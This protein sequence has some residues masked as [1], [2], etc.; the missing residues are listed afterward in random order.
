[1]LRVIVA[2]GREDYEHSRFRSQ[3]ARANAA[4]L[5]ITAQ[6]GDLRARGEPDQ[7]ARHRDGPRLRS[8]PGAAAAGSR[9]ANS[10][11]C[12][13]TSAR[14]T[15]RSRRSAAR[16]ACCRTD[17]STCR[18]RSICSRRSRTSVMRPARWRSAR[19]SGRVRFEH[20]S[21]SYPGR[22]GTLIDVTFEAAAGQAD[23]DR[24]TDWRRQE[25]AG[26]SAAAILR[27]QTGRV[28]VDGVDVR[29]LTLQVASAADQHRAAG[30]AAVL[31][32]DRRQHPLRAPR[33]DDGRD[34]RRRAS[35]ERARL[36]HAR[37]R[38]N[39]TRCLASAARSCREANASASP[40]PARS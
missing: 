25:H 4:R 14:S 13:R 40:W 37:C 12:W 32:L 3:G 1:M 17:S 27:R 39:T 16:S 10:S 2:F 22:T 15:S 29:T 28:L 7:R 31:G 18:S 30:A 34:R 21:F 24:G 38:S 9:S 6:A 11:S 20:V 23:R 33:C 5:M 36:R 26:Q 8:A 19:C 35:G